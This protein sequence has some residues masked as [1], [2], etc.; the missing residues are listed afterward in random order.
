MYQVCVLLK[1]RT[2][3]PAFRKFENKAF[4]LIAKHGGKLI[5]AF[6]TEQSPLKNAPDEIHVLEFASKAAFDAYRDDPA[7]LGLLAERN[8]VILDTIIYTSAALVTY[9][10]ESFD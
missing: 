3:K 8:A 2:A 7:A 10:D 4:K 1:Y 9:P 5:T 6:E